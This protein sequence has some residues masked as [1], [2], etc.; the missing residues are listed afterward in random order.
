MLTSLEFT[1][2][3]DCLAHEKERFCNYNIAKFTRFPILTLAL[4]KRRVE[5]HPLITSLFN[6]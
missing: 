5:A 6:S 4:R 2:W 1:L 3:I